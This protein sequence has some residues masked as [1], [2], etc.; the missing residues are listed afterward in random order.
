M[1]V[2]CKEELDAAMQCGCGEPGCT[3]KAEYLH[4]ACH[5]ESGLEVRYVDG[6]ME[7]RCNECKKPVVAVAIADIESYRNLYGYKNT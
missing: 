4:A 1:R 3:A 2:L 5:M 7:I 6:I